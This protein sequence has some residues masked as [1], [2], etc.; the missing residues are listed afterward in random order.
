MNSAAIS[1][2]RNAERSRV[3]HHHMQQRAMVVDR[4]PSCVGA[5]LLAHAHGHLVGLQQR[6]APHS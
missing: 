1:A 2:R 3:K 6:A 5:M 4:M